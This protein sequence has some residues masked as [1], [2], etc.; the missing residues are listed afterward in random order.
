M[1]TATAKKEKATKPAATKPV[2]AKAE[3]LGVPAV[4]PKVIA[5][6]G[7]LLAAVEFCA[8][9]AKSRVKPI[10][11]AIVIDVGKS[12][13]SL[14][15]TD[16]QNW[17][18]ANA[19]QV[20]VERQGSTAIAAATLLNV[21]RKMPDET[22]TLDCDGTRLRLSGDHSQFDLYTQNASEL[23]PAPR[24]TDEVKF[25]IDFTQLSAAL[26][27]VL[28]AVAKEHAT[29]AFCGI[30]FSAKGGR[31]AV[32]ATDGRR[33]FSDWLAASKGEASSIVPAEAIR[34]LLS[35]EGEIT[36]SL[37]PG[38]ASFAGPSQ[39]ICTTLIE[40]TFPPYDDITPKESDSRFIV[41]RS[42]LAS[43]LDQAD[44]MTSEETKGLRMAYSAKKVV[45]SSRTPGV[46]EGTINVGGETKG[47]AIEIGVNGQFLSDAIV[48][49]GETV[50]IE[51]TQPNRPMLVRGESGGDSENF[52]AVIM[53][54]NLQ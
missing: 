6:R 53:P 5:N 4:N 29:Y 27:R 16:L 1:A 34:R 39:S 47:P 18:S 26:S 54:V 44:T 35:L 15:S 3:S 22:V 24:P 25:D 23:T 36:V 7:E 2:E 33:L 30:L 42:E 52:R 38:H 46:G 14:R 11:A 21:L 40:G 9:A 20:Q 49:L 50:S 32:V 48:G 37:A 17:L 13:I 8:S 43:A 28:V 41:K 51:M 12:Q 19:G 10:L 45:I 31:L